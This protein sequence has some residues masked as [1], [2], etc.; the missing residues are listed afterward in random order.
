M[1]A[2]DIARI[3]GALRFVRPA[4]PG[5][6]RRER[7]AAETWALCVAALADLF[8]KHVRRFD[9]TAF[10][11]ACGVTLVATYREH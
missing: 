5:S 11:R 6:T 10:F 1:N 8:T 4:F 7:I 9:R 3:A 2:R